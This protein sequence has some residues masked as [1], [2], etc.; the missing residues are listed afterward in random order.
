MQ[1]LFL[2]S[3]GLQRKSTFQIPKLVIN[4]FLWVAENQMELLKSESVTE[5]NVQILNVHPYF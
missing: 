2:P 1:L 4:A 5:C 3:K